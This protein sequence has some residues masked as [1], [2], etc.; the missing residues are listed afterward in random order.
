MGLSMRDGVL[1]AVG[2]VN[3]TG[4]VLGRPLEPLVCDDRADVG[5]ADRIAHEL[6]RARVAATLGFVNTDPALSAT[7]YH[8]EAERPVI[9][10]CTAGIGIA[11]QFSGPK[12]PHNYVFRVSMDDGVIAAV[13]AEHVFDRL[14]M[15]RPAIFAATAYYGE[16]SRQDLSRRLTELGIPPVAQEA[17]KLGD[18]DMKP[19]VERARAAKADIIVTFGVGPEVAAIV[20]SM[21]DLGFKVPVIGSWPIGTSTFIDLAGPLAEGA[22]A[23]QTFI[24]APTTPRRKAFVEG[25]H[26]TYG[27]DRI[28]CAIAA[29]QGYDS[30]QVLAAAIAQAQSTAG[31]AIRAALE[32]L[33]EPVEGVVTTYRRPFTH[34][35]HEAVTTNI[36]VIGVV[37]G[38]RMTFWSPEDETNA[39]V[40]RIKDP[41]RKP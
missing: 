12:Y 31:P 23:P 5:E 39:H 3:R 20:K 17:F 8:Q 11:Q 24:E 7:R 40:M 21:A 35:D 6:I 1:L 36:P 38:S 2:D 41:D 37:R 18:R 26:R 22:M 14:R 25:Y 27:V 10:N 34:D 9:V 16:S 4:G 15:K 19:Q 13:I 33:E 32:H 28:P 30:V 29:A